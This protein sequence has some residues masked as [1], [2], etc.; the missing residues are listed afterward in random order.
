MHR[1]PVHLALIFLTVGAGGSAGCDEEYSDD[2]RG[3]LDLTPFYTSQASRTGSDT[4]LDPG[5]VPEQISAQNGFIDGKVAELYDFGRVPAVIDPRSNQPVAVRTAPMYFFYDESDRPLFS[6]PVRELREGIDWIKGGQQ[7]L[8]PNPKDW[9]T[10][11]ADPVACADQNAREK[12]RP[13]PLRTRDLVIDPARGTADYQRP[14]VDLIPGDNSPPRRQYTG[15]WEVME[16]KVPGKY[17]PD[18]IKSLATL[19]KAIDS[20]KYK[21]RR[22]GKVINC[23]I[24]DERTHV[25]RG[26][27]NRRIFRPRIELWYRGLLSTCFLVNGWETLGNAEGGVLFAGVDSDRTDTFDVSRVGLGQGPA[28]ELDLVVPI[29]RSYVPALVTDDQSGE[30]VPSLTRVANNLMGVSAPRRSRVDDPGYSPA[31][32]LFDVPAPANYE[33]G[34][35]KSIK[36]FDVSTAISRRTSAGAPYVANIAVRGVAQRCSFKPTEFVTPTGRT[37][38]RCGRQVQDPNKPPGNLIYDAKGDMTCNAERDPLNPNDL[39][40]ECNSETC[41]CD[42]P[43]VKYGQACGPGLARCSTEKDTFSEFGYECFPP[44][45]GFC[46]VFCQGT[47]TLAERNVGKDVKDWVDSRCVAPTASSVT[48]DQKGE[49]IPGF[50]C[51]GG[52]GCIKI[53]DQNITDPAQCKAEVKFGMQ[54]RDIQEGQTCQDF[55][56]HVCAWPDTHTPLDLP[57]PK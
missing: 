31:Q 4:S 51:F 38:E 33:S 11:G 45:G 34:A 3:V 22:T 39:P 9:C 24:I 53:C 52:I 23:P 57:V 35:W 50:V 7:V 26:I 37:V 49:P 30:G 41:F 29:G 5:E 8:N 27:T 14:I 1:R 19:A 10:P 55:G 48:P 2:R 6:R 28:A 15:F 47:N 46:Q 17:A 20:G 56:L 43:I 25:S 32:W 44:W 54:T 36:D 16:V 21:V 40:L 18:A 13:Y 42:A 12:M